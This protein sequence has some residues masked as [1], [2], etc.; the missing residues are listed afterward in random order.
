MFDGAALIF[1]DL[2]GGTGTTLAGMPDD[3]LD[4]LGRRR[5]NLREVYRIFGGPIELLPADQALI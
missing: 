2:A 4:I 1:K 5:A 3:D